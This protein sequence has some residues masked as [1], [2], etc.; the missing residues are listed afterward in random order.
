MDWI[1][2]NRKYIKKKKKE[3][4]QRSKPLSHVRITLEVLNTTM[5]QTSPIKGSDVM[6]QGWGSSMRIF[7]KLPRRF[8]SAVRVENH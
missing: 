3:F 2:K 5:P 8:H 6:G 1:F 7:S 4:M